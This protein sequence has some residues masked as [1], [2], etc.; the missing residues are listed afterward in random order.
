MAAI[1]D[2]DGFDLYGAEA[3]GDA[4]LIAHSTESL[5]LGGTGALMAGP[6]QGAMSTDE[7]LV[8]VEHSEH[9]DNIHP[10]LRV[11]DARTGA[12]VAELRDE[13][14]A[15][16]ASLVAD[17]G[18]PRRSGTAPRRACTGHL[19]RPDRRGHRPTSRGIGSPRSPTGGRTRLRAPVRAARRLTTCTGT[20][21]PAR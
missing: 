6:D 17:P 9:G 3:N 1:S 12:V 19:E 5:E 15:L 11:L 7:T 16:C 14:L 18:D 8:C 13:G 20:L 4:R 2:R 10:S 21:A